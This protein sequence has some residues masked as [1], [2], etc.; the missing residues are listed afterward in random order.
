MVTIA[1]ILVFIFLSLLLVAATL[2]KAAN[3]LGEIRDEF[4]KW[5]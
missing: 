3:I 4:R 1:I 2:D 5:E